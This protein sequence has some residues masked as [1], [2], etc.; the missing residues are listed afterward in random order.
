MAV[1]PGVLAAAAVTTAL[2]A[3]CTS[4]VGPGGGESFTAARLPTLTA[5]PEAPAP[6]PDVRRTMSA[7]ATLATFEAPL[8]ACRG[9]VAIDV[10]EAG[11]PLLV[12]EHDYCGGAAWIPGLDRGDV[13]ELDGPGVDAGLYRVDVVDRHQRRDVFVRDLRPSA[14]VVLQ[15]CVS[16]TQLVLVALSKVPE[17]DA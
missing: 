4:S 16:Q 14:D 8:D 11:R 5:A 6:R 12:S 13:V 15:T 3:G 10:Q 17:R 7:A 2:V 9:P 1:R